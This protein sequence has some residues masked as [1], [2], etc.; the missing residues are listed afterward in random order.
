MK[1]LLR[2]VFGLLLVGFGIFILWSAVRSRTG[3]LPSEWKRTIGEVIESDAASVQVGAERGSIA[4]LA[5]VHFRYQVLGQT[6]TGTQAFHSKAERDIPNLRSQVGLK[7]G[8]T[9]RIAYNPAQPQEAVLL[10]QHPPE[11]YAGILLGIL[12]VLLGAGLLVSLHYRP[13]PE[14]GDAIS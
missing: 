1:P 7:V 5:E 13:N 8:E 12:F 2:I 3:G 11:D 6:F 14:D 4:S 10:P 9:V